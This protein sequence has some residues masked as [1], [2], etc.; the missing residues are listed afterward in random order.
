MSIEGKEVQSGKVYR[1]SIPECW[2]NIPV[3]R[4]NVPVG[5]NKVRGVSPYSWP[6]LKLSQPIIF[7]LI[8]R[9]YS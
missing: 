6:I 3:D 9:G 2:N 8:L 1:N 4:N 5:R 7:V